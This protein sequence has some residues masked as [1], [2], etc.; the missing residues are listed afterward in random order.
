MGQVE[1]IKIDLDAMEAKLAE[2]G[3]RAGRAVAPRDRLQLG[4][5]AVLDLRRAADATWRRGS[6]DA[7]INRDRNLRLQY[8]AGHGPE[9]VSERADLCRDAR[10]HARFPENLFTGSPATLQALREAFERARG[11]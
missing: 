2:P 3:V 8:L 9:P 7:Q 6:T 4:G 1:P 11:R 5:R 10:A